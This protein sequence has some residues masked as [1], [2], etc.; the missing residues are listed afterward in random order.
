MLHRMLDHFMKRPASFLVKM[1]T[2][3]RID[4]RFNKAPEGHFLFGTRQTADGCLQGGCILIPLDVCK[5]MYE[6]RV[7]LSSELKDWKTSWGQMGNADNITRALARRAEDMKLIGFEWVLKWGCQK[8]GIET[9]DFKEVSSRWEFAEANPGLKY[10][11]IHPDKN[12]YL[13]SLVRSFI[14]VWNRVNRRLVPK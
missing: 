11:I 3:T 5:K 13:P 1:D 2:D 7:F 4:R 8:L 6:A 14:F 10:A 12:L 9:K